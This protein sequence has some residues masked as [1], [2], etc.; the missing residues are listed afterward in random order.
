MCPGIYPLLRAMT[1]VDR[2]SPNCT[3][4]ISLFA[5]LIYI[6]LSINRSDA[7]GNPSSPN[8]PGGE[9]DTPPAARRLPL[10]IILARDRYF[11]TNCIC[12]RELGLLCSL[13]GDGRSLSLRYRL[14]SQPFSDYRTLPWLIVSICIFVR[15]LVAFFIALKQVREEGFAQGTETSKQ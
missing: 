8:W 10:S 3:P 14:Y 6:T 13:S 1:H 11:H 15:Y 12:G 5:G 9:M 7:E 2:E 4:N